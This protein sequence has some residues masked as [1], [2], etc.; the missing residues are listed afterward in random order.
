MYQKVN[1]AK[2]FKNVFPDYETFKEWYS[3]LPLCDG[4]SDIPSV[5][6]FTLIAYEYNCSHLAMNEVVFKQHFAN[7][8]YTYYKEFEE[9]T[10]GI[11]DLMA[12]TDEEIK[13]ANEMI[14]N[15]AE[16]PEKTYSTDAT[17]ANFISAQQKTINRKGELQVKREKLSSKRTFTTKT[18]LKRFKH[19]FTVCLDTPYTFVVEEPEGE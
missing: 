3:Q 13:T 16:T 14:I 9:T 17:T 6:T 5:K 19:L 15:T 7:D 18:F 12:L 10:K 4:E 11:I 1:E 8:L 2:L